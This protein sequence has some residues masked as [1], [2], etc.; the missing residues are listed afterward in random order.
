MADHIRY[1][2]DPPLSHLLRGITEVDQKGVHLQNFFDK[3]SLSG[4]ILATTHA[5]DAIISGIIIGP[6][7]GY[8][9]LQFP[10][11]LFPVYGC[12]ASMVVASGTHTMFVETNARAR[13]WL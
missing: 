1:I 8:D 5:D 7:K 2:I 9:F 12:Q 13:I 6:P 11:A 4:A 3:N 10:F